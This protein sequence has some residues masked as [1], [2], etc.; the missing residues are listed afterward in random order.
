MRHI[1]PKRLRGSGGETTLGEGLS[2]GQGGWLLTSRNDAKPAAWRGA[3]GLE[4]VG[5]G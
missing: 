1:P 5:R 3:A 2:L 4:T